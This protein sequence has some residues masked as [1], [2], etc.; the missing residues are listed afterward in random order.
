MEASPII[1]SSGETPVV[2]CMQGRKVVMQVEVDDTKG[3]SHKTRFFNVPA[4]R[5]DKGKAIFEGDRDLI[6]EILIDGKPLKHRATA[7]AGFDGMLTLTYPETG[8]MV[9]TRT[10]YPSMTKALVLDEWQL[11][12]T[13]GKAGEGVREAVPHRKTRGRKGGH[14]LA[15]AGGRNHHGRTRRRVHVSRQRPG[16]SDR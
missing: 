5:V 1:S 15:N 2:L 4:G 12:N 13:S 9:A 6:P 3:F 16:P 7:K 14:D 11:R 8:G 10:I